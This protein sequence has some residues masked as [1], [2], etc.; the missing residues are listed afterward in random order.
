MAKRK[1]PKETSADGREI[2]ICSE[3]EC[4]E[5]GIHTYRA[6]KCGRCGNHKLEKAE[7]EEWG[8]YLGTHP[9]MSN[10]LGVT[11]EPDEGMMDGPTLGRV[12]NVVQE[13]KVDDTWEVPACLNSCPIAPQAQVYIPDEMFKQWVDLTRE[14]STEWI[15]YLQGKAIPDKPFSWEIT[16]MTFPRQKANSAHVEI[17]DEERPPTGTVAT[18]HS[19]VDFNVFFSSEDQKHFNWPVE[20]VVNRRGEIKANGLVTLEC[21]RPH[22]GD[23][24]VWLTGREAY[25]TLAN[26]LKAVLTE[27]KLVVQGGQQSPEQQQTATVTAAPVNFNHVYMGGKG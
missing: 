19:H 21:G 17:E 6:G 5:F 23:A 18:V 25:R 9:A 10:G 13:P 26:Q 22:R 14:I 20:L 4:K 12:L 16:G 3:V 24:K 11:F 1:K 27:E 8:D 2:Y 7:W 15:A